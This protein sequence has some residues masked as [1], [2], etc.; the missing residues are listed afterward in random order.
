VDSSVLEEILRDLVEWPVTEAELRSACHFLARLGQAP[1][2]ALLLNPEVGSGAPKV[3][4]RLGDG[5]AGAS[6][7][8]PLEA[9]R[10]FLR[11]QAARLPA[12]SIPAGVT[13]IS[14]DGRGL[15]GLQEASDLNWASVGPLWIFLATREPISNDQKV[16][17]YAF[18]EHLQRVAAKNEC[19]SAL[20]LRSQFL[21]IASHELKTPLTSIYGVLQL[22]ERML[23][24]KNNEEMTST[25][26]EKQH[27][28]LK[29]VIRQVERLNELIDGLL[30]VSRIQV[31]RF[32][33][34]P[35]ETDVA[36][37]LRDM[38]SSR[39]QPIAADA[40]VRIHFEGPET[41]EAWVDPVR[42]EEVITNLV[43]NAIRFSPE[44]GAIWVKLAVDNGSFRLIVRDQGPS[45]PLED[46]E[47][48]FQPFER[49]QRTS[50][51]GGLGLGL[52]ISRQ[53]AQLHGGNV[54]L[55][56][57]IPGRGNAFEASFPLRAA[58]LA[59]A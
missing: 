15:P 52:F 54:S 46:R 22:Q 45:V 4:C 3:V 34:E 5:N 7:P 28:F 21:S 8:P 41:L 24:L 27:A 37:L 26:R 2:T 50:R 20:R 12:R 39:L 43:M 40:G 53:I 32:T 19:D 33:I 58:S 42:M 17:L 10:D 56:E 35:A 11:R 38:I 16:G 49:A 31:G 48:I 13:E 59:S 29:M 9:T 55:A 25:Y 47:R 51:L 1:L 44:G 14:A 18:I 6:E 30:D 23:R 57:S 36:T